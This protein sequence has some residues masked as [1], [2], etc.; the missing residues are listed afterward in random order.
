VEL[1]TSDGV[2]DEED[3]YS[4]DLECLEA[5]KPPKSGCQLS[6]EILS[7]ESKRRDLGLQ[8]VATTQAWLF[9]VTPNVRAK[10][11]VEADADWP[12]KDNL[13]HGLKRPGGGCRSGS[14]P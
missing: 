13:P 2:R 6:G 10:A 4:R 12:R 1:A 8:E 9:L 11:T 5:A 7:G 14:P 3:G